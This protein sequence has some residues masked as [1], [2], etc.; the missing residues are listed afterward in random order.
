MNLTLNIKYIQVVAK[1][2]RTPADLLIDRMGWG[3]PVVQRGDASPIYE[4]RTSV[5]IDNPLSTVHSPEMDQT[6]HMPSTS[7]VPTVV[8]PVSTTAVV[9]QIQSPS[10]IIE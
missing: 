5:I 2:Y 4:R 9:E 1:S 3:S 7:L 6:W 8:S 10:N